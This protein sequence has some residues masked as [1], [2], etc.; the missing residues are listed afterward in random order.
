[1]KNI[2]EICG[3][4]R[5]FNGEN[6]TCKVVILYEGKRIPPLPVD[7]EDSCFF[8]NKFVASPYLFKQEEFE[9]NV[10]QVKFWV[11]DADENG[12]GEVKIQYEDG[13]FGNEEI[14]L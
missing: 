1:M 2:K 5:L 12:N 9:V 11:E 8:H 6:S 7:P 10:K 4:C 14:E 3:N 13:F